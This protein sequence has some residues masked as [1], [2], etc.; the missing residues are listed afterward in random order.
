MVINA[1]VNQVDV[2]NMRLGQRA[3]IRFD[4]FPGLELPGHVVTI[5]AITKSAGTRGAFKKEVAVRL[6]LDKLDPR[7]IPDLSV[8]ADIV[9]EEADSATVVPAEALMSDAS[10]AGAQPKPFVMV[11]GANGAWIRRD[12]QV[13]LVSNTHAAI[14]EGL[15]PGE[16]VALEPPNVASPDKDK[17]STKSS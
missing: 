9:L 16:A 14:R 7:I 15:K 13:G 17:S 8:S 4:A 6:R 11:R 5:G 10:V 2:Q 3:K 12:V 1:A